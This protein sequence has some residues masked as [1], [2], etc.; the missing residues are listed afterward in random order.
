MIEA[1]GI[2]NDFRQE[3]MA[4]VH[5][6]FSH[7]A[8]RR[9][10]VFNLSVPFGNTEA[11]IDLLSSHVVGRYHSLYVAR[12]GGLVDTKRS[13][14]FIVYCMLMRLQGVPQRPIRLVSSRLDQ[15]LAT[16]GV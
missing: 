4:F 1:Y 3:T 9:R 10:I 15:P 8:N 5:L 7:T 2:L 6:R 11:L 16:F 13:T 14:D 12:D